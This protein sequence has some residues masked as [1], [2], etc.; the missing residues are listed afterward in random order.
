MPKADARGA[1]GN[2]AVTEHEPAPVSRIAKA[3]GD[4]TRDPRLSGSFSKQ[5]AFSAYH[6]DADRDAS[7]S[8]RIAGACGRFPSRKGQPG[9]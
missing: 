7:G 3:L 9:L 4:R 2:R 6:P 5:G 1:G 8:N